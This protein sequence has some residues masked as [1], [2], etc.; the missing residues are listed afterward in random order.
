MYQDY[1]STNYTSDPFTCSFFWFACGFTLGGT[2]VKNVREKS[3]TKL[4]L[5]TVVDLLL[6]PVH[7]PL[8]CVDGRCVGFF[9][10]TLMTGYCLSVWC[11]GCDP[12]KFLWLLNKAFIFFQ[13]CSYDIE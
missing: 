8:I 13:L 9:V 1:T 11:S 2:T 6:V 4:W 3:K 12:A 10:H 5:P 7:K